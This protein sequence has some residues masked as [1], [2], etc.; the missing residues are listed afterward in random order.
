M[1]LDK[2]LIGERIRKIREEIFHETRKIFAKR[3]D[4]SERCIGQIERGEFLLS[5]QTLNKIAAATG[6]DTDYILY[7]K[8]FDDTTGIKQA[9]HSIVDRSDLQQ[10]NLYYTCITNIINY[11]VTKYKKST[12]K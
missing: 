11:E 9:L 4:L 1:A 6:I 2:L 8:N 5:L 12:K 7:G 10:L 3:C